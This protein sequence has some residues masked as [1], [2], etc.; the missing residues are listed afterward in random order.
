MLV[1]ACILSTGL[2]IWS[3]RVDAL[4]DYRNDTRA[5]GYVLAEQT[6][7]Y[8]QVI[9]LVLQEV[10]AYG[11]RGPDPTPEG[12]RVR[13]T[14]RAAHAFLRARMHNLP[15]AHALAVIGP[16]GRLL[17]SSRMF[18]A[19]HFNVADRDFFRHFVNH[20]DDTGLFVSQPAISRLVGTPTLFV[21]R[22]IETADHRLLGIAIAAIDISYLHSV[23]REI[24]LQAGRTVTVLRRDGMVL[25]R[26]P[27]PLGVA[28][29]HLPTTSRWYRQRARGGG[30]Y[31][32][33]G[34]FGGAPSLVSVHPLQHYPLVVDT[35]IALHQALADWRKEAIRLSI[36]AGS[37]ILALLVLFSVI[38]AQFR[39]LAKQNATLAETAVALH[40]SERR[41]R[42]FAEVASDWFWEQDASLCFT[43]ISRTAPFDGP[44][45]RPFIGK[46]RL[47]VVGA[48]P[49]D[50]RWVAH[51]Q[52][53]RAHRP[54][55]DLRYQR[56]MSD[57][58][59]RHVSVSGVPVFD[60]NGRFVG[61]RGTGRDVTA[62]VVAEAELRQ[63]KDHAEA[64]NR[65][66]SEFLAT[67]S[68]ELRTPLN[69]I[70]GFSELIRDQ[71]RGTGAAGHAEFAREIHAGGR[72]L[73]ELINDLLDFSRI[74]AGRYELHEE[75]VRLSPLLHR[76][77]GMLR[78]RAKQGDVF[79]SCQPPDD[80]LA[81]HADPRAVRQVLL[82]LLE[83]AVK[84]TPRGGSVSL[85][86]E[87]AQ[88]DGLAI[89]VRDSGIG[90]DPVKLSDLGEPF[91][92]ADASISR[93]FGGTGLG[94]AISRRLL[95][96]HG[97]RLVIDSQP[98]AGT[99][100]RAVFPAARVVVPDQMP[101]VG[102]GG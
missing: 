32:S 91:R 61:Y 88:D 27:D 70:I 99:T 4:A 102:Q 2:L 42:D 14:T 87:R 50:P 53:L 55:R 95:Q 7:R 36:G 43:W 89:V 67:M 25:V 58:S 23:Y 15:Q 59:V 62:D 92:Q 49:N 63:A 12:F 11:L 26:H 41:V 72:H 77:I 64:A 30:T 81:L 56:I 66:K 84:F 80:A 93:R 16:G 3:L 54:F 38:A 97:G 18:P 37:A 90:I 6:S 73:L 51:E 94:L 100:A 47:E 65:A 44:T 20:P 75:T 74:D 40:E 86:A 28:G 101:M 83:N 78:V 33:A 19:P 35:A 13:L 10:Q 31:V 24:R 45:D 9:D 1:A 5:L 29:R 48:D 17:A 8:L 57:G 82:N 68:H 96:L 52:T 60:G 98:G 46:T 76:C 34:L 22:R 85:T 21:A 69:A 71:A 39:R 79:L